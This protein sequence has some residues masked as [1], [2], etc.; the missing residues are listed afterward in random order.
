MKDKKIKEEKKSKVLFFKFFVSKT[1]NQFQ[2]NKEVI[3][4]GSSISL[5]PIPCHKIRS[6]YLIISKATSPVMQFFL[7][8]VFCQMCCY[9]YLKPMVSHDRQK[10]NSKRFQNCYFSPGA[11]FFVSIEACYKKRYIFSFSTGN[12]FI[13][14]HN[15]F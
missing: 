9:E 14:D 10:L 6:L 7:W 11:L 2:M 5:V 12:I 3:M 13:W 1:W 4:S 8:V 15:T